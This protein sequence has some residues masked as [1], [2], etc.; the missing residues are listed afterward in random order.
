MKKALFTALLA[1]LLGACNQPSTYQL[2]GS[3]HEFN[4]GDTVYLCT[5]SKS[6]K[7][8]IRSIIYIDS[9]IVDNGEIFFQGKQDSTISVYL[10]THQ[11]HSQ[12]FFLENGHLRIKSDSNYWSV[13]GS[14]YN[15]IFQNYLKEERPIRAEWAKLI[16]KVLKEDTLLTKEQKEK[17]LKKIKELRSVMN[18]INKRYFE[19]NI[20][21]PV[22][23]ELF[24]TAIKEY[25]IKKQKELIDRAH[26]LWPENDLISIYKEKTD[27]KM[28]SLVG[29]KFIDFTMQDPDGR[30]LSLSDIIKKQNYTLVY[31]WDSWLDTHSSQITYLVEAYEKYKNKGF[32]IV[33]VALGYDSYNWK[34]AIKQWGVTWPQIS[35]LK[36]YESQIMKLYA[37]ESIPYL[38]LIDQD[39]TIVARNIGASELDKVLKDF[40]K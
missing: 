21:N 23:V 3:L 18:S 25:N 4:N 26:A 30:P 33:A 34:N 19:T 38:L 1:L 36:G 28:N 17:H 31:V 37:I 7:N 15:D 9:C 27:K 39:G 2:T 16:T 8:G 14:T 11:R 20:D 22:G 12:S 13:T 5:L 10:K 32:G 29:E 35:D 40:M 24:V 6:N